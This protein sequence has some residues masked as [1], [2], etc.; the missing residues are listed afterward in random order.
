MSIKARIAALAAASLLSAAGI[1]HIKLSE[2]RHTTAYPDPATGGAPW[3]ICYG[4]TGPEVKPGLKVSLEQCELWLLEDTAKAERAVKRLTKV[5]LRQGQYDAA[6][7]FV[8]N[9]GEGNYA[10]STLL[11]LQNAGQW[12][13]A[14]DQYPRWKYANKR[15]LEGLVTRR[16]KEQTMCRQEGPYVYR[17]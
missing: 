9:L 11:R 1:A 4:H 5:P 8:F 17:P 3:T 14:C 16:Y 15:V 10:S 6:T 7:S 2:G 13:S 12:H